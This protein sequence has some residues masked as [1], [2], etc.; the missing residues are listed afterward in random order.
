MGL[1]TVDTSFFQAP[2]RMNVYDELGC[3]VIR[4]DTWVEVRGGNLNR[5]EYSFDLGNMPDL[6]P[7]L[8]VLAT[9]RFGRTLIRNVGHLRFKE[10]DR[11]QALAREF[12][13]LGIQARET[14][15]G[16]AVEGGPAK[17]AAIATYEDHRIAMSFAI[18]GLAVPGISIQ[19]PGCV[20]KSFPEFWEKLGGLYR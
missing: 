15:D 1:R 12:R 2:G 7:G 4:G 5:G 6:V 16:L 13:K 18:L 9:R 10:S 11:L 8:A 17:G 14:E 20:G 3:R 19:N